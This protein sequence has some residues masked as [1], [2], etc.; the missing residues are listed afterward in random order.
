[1]VIYLE[2]Q[3]YVHDSVLW[4]RECFLMEIA[5]VSERFYSLDIVF[6]CSFCLCGDYFFTWVIVFLL[7]ESIYAVD[8]VHFA[9]MQCSVKHKHCKET[10]MEFILLRYS[11]KIHGPGA[12]FSRS[13]PV[14]NVTGIQKLHL[15][16]FNL[17]VFL[18]LVFTIL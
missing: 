1:M 5:R 4:C 14:W 16:F 18:I 12:I 10:K 15:K 13:F 3:V 9:V 6:Y 11:S 7:L 2:D 8:G 17:E